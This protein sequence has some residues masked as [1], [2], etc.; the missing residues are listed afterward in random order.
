[1][2]ALRQS[3][4]RGLNQLHLTIASVFCCVMDAL[5]VPKILSELLWQ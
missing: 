4:W 5:S 1:M 3:Y 2:C